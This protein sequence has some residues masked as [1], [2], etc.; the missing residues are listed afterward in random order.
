METNISN[1]LTVYGRELNSALKD[2]LDY[3]TTFTVDHTNGG[4]VGRISNDNVIEEAA[5]KGAVLNARIL[6]SF[7]A[8]YNAGSLDN[9]DMAERAYHYITDHFIDK[10]YGG[11]YWTTDH[12]GNPKDTKKQVYALAFTIYAFSE[13]FIACGN[14][15]VKDHAIVLYKDLIKYSYDPDKGGYFEAFNRQW[16]PMEDLR[17]SDKDANEKKTM[18]TH[19]HVLEAFSNLYKIWPEEDLKN[20]II[21]LIKNFTTHIVDPQTGQMTL[22]FDE[23]W[24]KRSDIIS[25]GHDIEASWLLLEAAEVVEDEEL[26]SEVK[27][28]AVKMAE[29]A[30]SGLDDDGALWYEKESEEHIIKE[31]HWWVQAEA[32]IGFFN[33]WQISGEQ[34]F[35]S[36]SLGTWTYVKDHLL[37]KENGEWFWGINEEGQVMSKEDKVGIWKCPYHNSR[38]C[39][40]LVKRIN[41]E[42]LAFE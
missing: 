38:A 24:S 26:I 12:L 34:R 15:V 28:L 19:L 7:S 10:D 2:I 30:L 29:G 16:E 22:F 37:D 35:L 25:Y 13:Y 11:V 17:L 4:F 41:N 9:L 39:L 40:E 42:L 21:A 23:D 32:M 8:A 36:S 5:D 3:W 31:K 18:N 14:D 6:W 33:A 20:H 1:Q 27:V